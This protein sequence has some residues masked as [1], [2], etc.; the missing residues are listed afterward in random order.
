MPSRAL[1]ILILEDNDDLRTGWLDFFQSQGH[2]VRGVALADELL[3]KS[4]EF[5]P[6]VYIIDLNLPDAD[7]L[8]VVKRLRGVHPNAGI[9][10]TTARTLIGDKVLGYNSGADIYFIKPVDPQELMAGI[11]SLAKRR[12]Q[13]I[14][15]EVHLNL[16]PDRHLLKGPVLNVDLT[17]I[18]TTL[19]VSLVRA[20]GQPLSRWQ[21]AELLGAGEGLPTDAM[22]EMRIARLRKR[23][24]AAG[25]DAPAIKAIH[26]KGYVLSCR[27]VIDS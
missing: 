21:I 3:D 5:S 10:I 8:D 1:K 25:A 27:V 17:P 7:G 19:L 13:P 9:V 24:T 23:L 26:K 6:D 12:D 16:L 4:V 18:E 14:G 2:F 15:T 11:T 22:L 20:S